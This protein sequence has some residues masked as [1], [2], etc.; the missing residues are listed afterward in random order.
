MQP[1][2]AMHSKY[3]AVAALGA[4]PQRELLASGDATERLW[5]AWAICTQLGVDA[6]PLVRGLAFDGA[7]EGLRQQILVVVAGLG[8]R[9]VLKAIAEADPSVKVR[10]TAVRYYLRTAGAAADE[11]IEFVTPLLQSAAPDIV[12]AI[13]GEHDGGR[14]S[15]P[16]PVLVALLRSHE[17]DVRAGAAQCLFRPRPHRDLLHLL[18]D[19][20]DNEFLKLIVGLV[21]RTEVANLLSV[22]TGSP[23]ALRVVSLVRRAFGKLEWSE[24]SSIGVGSTALGDFELVAAVLDCLAPPPPPEAIGWI[25]LCFVA[26]MGKRE[27][28]ASRTSSL[29]RH[30]LHESLSVTTIGSLTTDARVALRQDTLELLADLAEL[31]VRADEGEEADEYDEW[32]D[33]AGQTARLEQLAELLERSAPGAE[34]V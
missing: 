31:Q 5:A 29:A 26:S 17:F 7:S 12:L 22:L 9:E 19:E 21:P 30:M 23:N 4:T 1:D 3:E 32:Y 28:A 24:L 11:A 14:V 10:A 20:S 6:L 16:E 34:A 33:I 8:E 25:G 15:I 27:Y 18:R 13:L 2:N